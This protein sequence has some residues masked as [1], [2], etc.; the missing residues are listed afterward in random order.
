LIVGRDAELDRLRALSASQQTQLTECR[1]AHATLKAKHDGLADE[2]AERERERALE[3]EKEAEQGRLRERAILAAQTQLSEETQRRERAERIVEER[4]SELEQER[5][6]RQGTT[7]GLEGELA[8][9]KEK[10]NGLVFEAEDARR[11]A[12]TRLRDMKERDNQTR[13]REAELLAQLDGCRDRCEASGRREAALQERERALESDVAQMERQVQAAVEAASLAQ[14]AQL[15][16]EEHAKDVAAEYNGIRT[17]KSQL[18][19]VIDRQRERERELSH[20]LDQAE[21]E[22]ER[23]VQKVTAECEQT[24]LELRVKC[25]RR[26]REMEAKAKEREAQREAEREREGASLKKWKSECLSLRE[27][28]DRL[29]RDL[30]A[31]REQKER[32]EREAEEREEERAREQERQSKGPSYS[33]L[34]AIIADMRGEMERARDDLTRCEAERDAALASNGDIDSQVAQRERE[35]AEW[36][37][38]AETERS[39][40][41]QLQKSLGS[42]QTQL[43]ALETSSRDEIELCKRTCDERVQEAAREMHAMQQDLA[44]AHRQV[45]VMKQRERDREAE[46]SGVALPSSRLPPTD[47]SHFQRMAGKLREAS[48]EIRRRVEKE[49]AWKD[50]REQ[51]ILKQRLLEQRLARHEGGGERHSLGS[52]SRGRGSGSLGSDLSRTFPS[53]PLGR[54]ERERSV[55]WEDGSDSKRHSGT[56]PGSRFTERVYLGDR[57]MDTE[58]MSE[59]GIDLGSFPSQLSGPSSPMGGGFKSAVRGIRDI[60]DTLVDGSDDTSYTNDMP[61]P[62]SVTVSRREREGEREREG[63]SVPKSPSSPLAIHGDKPR[64]HPV[65]TRPPRQ[66][67]RETVSQRRQRERIGETARQAER[68]ADREKKERPKNPWIKPK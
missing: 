48:L 31:L 45:E 30:T 22:R 37:Q 5:A 18:E 15:S 46:D 52:P 36:R 27:K 2:A 25:D 17:G 64:P 40:C 51:L 42:L 33:D 47:P 10:C 63:A 11:L 13:A 57:E 4:E 60:V 6:D 21:V 50:E 55:S 58:S 53:H 68:E 49:R 35:A 26:V 24:T 34:K 38:Q 1:E 8:L 28:T 44:Q 41:T 12:A 61:V 32:V 29:E 67:D 16:A 9:L 62:P 20:R 23:E 3:R 65:S 39:R 66:S 19:T 56:V 59:S 14:Q 43:S 7:V 54:S